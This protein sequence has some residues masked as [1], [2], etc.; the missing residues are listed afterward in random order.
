MESCW[1]EHLTWPEAEMALYQLPTVLLPLG[2]RTKEHGRHLPLNNDWRIA[3][4]LARRV[5]EQAPVLVLPTL[6]YGYYPAFLEYAGSISVRSEAFR[7]TVIDICR[8][9]A[10]HGARRFYVL[11]TGISTA[12]PLQ[13]ARATLR[14]EGT[15][16]EFTDIGTAYAPLRR[17]IETQP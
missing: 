2:A 17:Q 3:E 7:D 4:Y 1:L 8:S 13:A 10:N 12:P 14:A 15:R 11:N 16:F 5:A 6:E 9:L